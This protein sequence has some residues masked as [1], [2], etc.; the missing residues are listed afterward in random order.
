M[1]DLNGEEIERREEKKHVF[2]A[3]KRN[4]RR[5]RLEEEISISRAFFATGSTTLRDPSIPKEPSETFPVSISCERE[6][7]GQDDQ[8]TLRI[9]TDGFIPIPLRNVMPLLLSHRLFCVC[10]CGDDHGIRARHLTQRERECWLVSEPC[11]P[12]K[13]NYK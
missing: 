10:T 6:R 11:E 4:R 2:C 8:E 13:R 7:G 12:P 5:M 3:L 9:G 1:S